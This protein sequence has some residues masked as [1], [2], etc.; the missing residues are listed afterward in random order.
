MLS[1]ISLEGA[2]E[3]SNAATLPNEDMNRSIRIG[4]L[5][6]RHQMKVNE[7]AGDIC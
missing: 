3:I 6:E 1:Y 7:V 2:K 4:Y 5:W